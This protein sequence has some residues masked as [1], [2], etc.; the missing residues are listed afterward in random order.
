MSDHDW[1]RLPADPP[2]PCYMPPDALW[3]VWTAGSVVPARAQLPGSTA[4]IEAAWA[5]GAFQ[6][7]TLGSCSSSCMFL[8]SAYLVFPLWPV[9]SSSV[10]SRDTV[11]VTVLSWALSQLCT[12]WSRVRLLNEPTARLT[13]AGTGALMLAVANGES[14]LPDVEDWMDRDDED[15]GGCVD[16]P[17]AN[18]VAFPQQ[19]FRIRVRAQH[20]SR[21]SAPRGFASMRS[22]RVPSVCYGSL[23]RT[24]MPR[25][26]HSDH[27]LCACNPEQPEQRL[28]DARD[29]MRGCQSV[30]P[31]AGRAAGGASPVRVPRYFLHPGPVHSAAP[32]G[33][34]PLHRTFCFVPA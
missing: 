20:R 10:Q 11:L 2:A 5:S 24:L 34:S 4:R 28:A 19:A 17:D 18:F 33:R 12:R 6:I 21:T 7:Q 13:A 14:L 30:S 3:P 25:V 8:Q 29:L 32:G 1:I 23:Q 31:C 22:Y 16:G 9:T 15:D 27:T 26:M